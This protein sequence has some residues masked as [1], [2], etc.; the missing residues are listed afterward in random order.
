[1]V[2]E[3]R[4]ILPGRYQRKCRRDATRRHGIPGHHRQM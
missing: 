2:S 3:R 1:M 4:A